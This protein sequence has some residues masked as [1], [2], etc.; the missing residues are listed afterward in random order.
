[1]RESNDVKAAWLHADSCVIQNF[2]QNV[3]SLSQLAGELGEFYPNFGSFGNWYVDARV[4][5][6]AKCVTVKNSSQFFGLF[7]L[8]DTIAHNSPKKAHEQSW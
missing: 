2:S 6:W 5:K 3:F 4:Q 7:G 8:F 1:M